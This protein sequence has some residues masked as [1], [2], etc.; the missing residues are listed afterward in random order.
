MNS[1]HLPSLLSYFNNSS[2]EI[3]F[4]SDSLLLVRFRSIS[5]GYCR[6]QSENKS[7]M[8]SLMIRLCSLLHDVVQ[9]S[10]IISKLGINS[11]ASLSFGVGLQS[12]A[13]RFGFLASELS[14]LQQ[15]Q[16]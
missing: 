8:S 11:A 7:G 12:M 9:L 14:K 16:R 15:Q 13:S 3:C 6:E 10:H 4:V 5:F 2:V 1:F